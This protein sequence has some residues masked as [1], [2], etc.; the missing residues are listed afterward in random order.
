MNRLGLEEYCQVPLD[1]TSL[2]HH[3]VELWF[4]LSYCFSCTETHETLLHMEYNIQNN[5]MKTC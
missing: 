3:T 2:L 4:K 1:N 5:K